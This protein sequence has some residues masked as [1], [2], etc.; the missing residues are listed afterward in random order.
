V[1]AFKE[2]ISFAHGLVLGQAVQRVP[3]HSFLGADLSRRLRPLTAERASYAHFL[4]DGEV[5]SLVDMAS[6]YN[7]QAK[8]KR[9]QERL[10]LLAHHPLSKVTRLLY[11]LC[12]IVLFLCLFVMSLSVSIY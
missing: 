4:L 10:I 8:L 12:S 6:K 3:R 1:A 9:T 7:P 2:H 11:V 5:L